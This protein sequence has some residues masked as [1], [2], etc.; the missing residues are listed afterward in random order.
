MDVKIIENEK[1][2]V[3][4]I[5]KPQ[6]L[7]FNEKPAM[8]LLIGVSYILLSFFVFYLVWNNSINL[9]LAFLPLIFGIFFIIASIVLKQKRQSIYL[10][11]LDAKILTIPDNVVF[12]LENTKA[13]IVNRKFEVKIKR[14]SSKMLS[15]TV[16]SELNNNRLY[17]VPIWEVIIAKSSSGFSVLKMVGKNPTDSSYVPVFKFAEYL[18]KKLAVPII[19]NTGNTPFE[20]PREKGGE[21]RVKK[22]EKAPSMLK[23]FKYKE[24]LATPNNIFKFE[25][26]KKNN[27]HILKI[28]FLHKSPSQVKIISMLVLFELFQ[29]ILLYN[30]YRKEGPSKAF[31]SNVLLFGTLTIIVLSIIL[32]MPLN[33]F[34]IK[35]IVFLLPNGLVKIKKINGLNW[36][37]YKIPKEL[38]V[39]IN[40]LNLNTNYYMVEI[41]T[42]DKNRYFLTPLFDK[43]GGKIA[44]KLIE[45]LIFYYSP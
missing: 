25:S 38:I 29:L 19:D 21:L 13:I 12:P 17:S 39:Q 42:K 22:K 8:L 23:S 6:F 9:F 16:P 27:L 32:F 4:I 3:K 33:L 28:Y 1:K 26:N 2:S 30:Q 11:D 20:Y 34:N 14:T 44:K 15:K 10:L 41:I 31:Y 7:K 24:F 35:N 5:F 40:N 36:N 37:V 18:A 45:E 43:D